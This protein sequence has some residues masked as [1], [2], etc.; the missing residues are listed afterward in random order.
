M[1]LLPLLLPLPA[2]LVGIQLVAI[3]AESMHRYQALHETG[4]PPL[5]ERLCG[6]FS[7]RI[8]HTPSC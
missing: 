7:L 4:R 6:V 8:Q 3:A 2:G 1:L 5:A